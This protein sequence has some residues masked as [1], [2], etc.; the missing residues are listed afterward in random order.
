MKQITISGSEAGRRL[1]QFVMRLLPGAGMSFL[2]KMIRK[3]NITVNEH[4]AEGTYRLNEGDVVRIFFSD[5][6][7]EKFASAQN[8]KAD[9]DTSR[10]N[11]YIRAYHELK[12]IKIVYEDKDFIF[13]NKPVG[14]LSQKSTPSD[15]SLNEWLIGR[16][17]EQEDFDPGSTF[18]PAFCNR[19]D[20]NTTGL[21][22]GGK[23]LR[24]LQVLSEALKERTAHKYY[25]AELYGR[26]DAKLDINTDSFVRYDAFLVK[27]SRSNTVKIYGDRNAA[28]NTCR[29]PSDVETISTS[30]RLI[31]QKN[32]DTM[33][34]EI[35]LHTGKSHQIRAHM[36]YLGHPIVGDPKYGRGRG[37][38]GDGKYQCLHAYKVVFPVLEQFESIS[39]R[40]FTC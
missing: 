6:T 38:A 29:K 33:T 37:R 7:F 34:V 22:L 23:S 3:K 28:L 24:A 32:E 14:V 13:V 27:D 18:K 11:E 20:R 21:V 30:V 36:A 5:E 40:E 19:L 25:K 15:M 9:V 10:N 4:R 31:E 17:I 39:G 16:L 26:P 1:D 12:G 2:Q 35:E 8:K